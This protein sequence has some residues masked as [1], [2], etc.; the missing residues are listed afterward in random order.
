MVE[1]LLPRAS[2]GECLRFGASRVARLTAWLMLAAVVVCTVAVAIANGV[3]V[4]L[5]VLPLG[6]PLWP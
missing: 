3:V 5:T 1:E 4:L 6:V 2:S